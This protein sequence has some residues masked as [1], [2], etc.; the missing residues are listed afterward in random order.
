MPDGSSV[1]QKTPTERIL[2]VDD[3]VAILESLELLLN[4]AGYITATADSGL[5]CLDALAAENCDL[6]LLDQMLPD[7]PGLEILAEIRKQ[8]LRLP[9]MMLTAFGSIEMAVKSIQLGANNFLTKPWSNNKL[10]LEIEQALTRHRLEE[11][12]ARLRSQLGFQA[13]LEN[14]I[15]KSKPM[16]HVFSLITQIAPTPS[17]VLISGES[18]TGKELVAKAIHANS[19]RIE[20]P[21][22][23]VNSGS[24]PVDLMESTLFGHVKGSFAGALK[25]RKGSFE[26][27]HQG[28]IFLDEVGTLSPEL[29]SKLLRVIQEREFTPV[30][31]NDPTQIDVRIIAATNDNLFAAV[32]EGRFRE[33]LYYRLNVIGIEL[34][35]L[36]ERPGDLPLLIQ[37]YLTFF[38][39]REQNNY[40]DGTEKSTLQFSAD[41][42]RILMDHNWPG[43]VRELRNTVERAVVLAKKRELGPEVLP[44]LML[45]Q[46]GLILPQIHEDFQPLPRSSLPEIVENFERNLIL[47]QLKKHKYSQT[48]TAKT[49]CV[50]LSTLN[51]K[52]QRLGIKVKQLKSD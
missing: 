20:K 38:C 10:L 37:H 21:F 52:I 15:G 11:E 17:T 51:Q 5:A 22:I 28:T 36:R 30:G 34:P 12:N 4:K 13:G 9:I 45:E 8:D 2:I 48:E 42:L 39:K 47:G 32:K 40:L 24:V 23:T 16:K 14:I 6:V 35:P 19:P 44:K 31:S 33:D 18:G 43:N 7:K 25:D 1:L 41:A 3:E 46:N 26:L 29:Q 50:A 27:A 49:L